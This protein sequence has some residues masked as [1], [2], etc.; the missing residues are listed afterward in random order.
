MAKGV[1]G[2]IMCPMLEDELVYALSKDSDIGRI[3]V[4]ENE[5]CGSIKRKLDGR[6]VKYDTVPEKDFDGGKVDFDC[7]IFNIVIK[8][9]DLA[10][11]AEPPL[12]K[13]HLTLQ[14]ISMQVHA[15]V[16]GMYYGI[17]GNHGWD[18]SAWARE[19]SLKPVF[20]FRGDD[21]EVCDDCVAVAIGGSS[22]YRRFIKR[23]TGIFFLTPAIAG[24][25][26]DFIMA[27]DSAKG[28]SNIPDETLEALGIH[29]QEDFMRWLFEVGHYEFLLKMNTGLEPG[30][31]FDGEA[32]RIGKALN[33]KP[34]EIE[35]GW[36][37]LNTAESLYRNCKEAM[38]Q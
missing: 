17:C 24:N 5:Y 30:M 20:V 10:L 25:W 34:I 18:I 31:D 38:P 7:S 16:I 27:G 14:V 11:H 15:D 13:E 29:G 37:T 36:L 35:D 21:G 4:L 33:L 3:V 2:L 6:G 32:E 19:N 26:Q 23:Y 28:L 9:N 22:N 12:L 8:A 1:L